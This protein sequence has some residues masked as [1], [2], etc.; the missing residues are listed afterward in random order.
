MDKRTGSS[1]WGGRFSYTWSLM[2]DNQWGQNTAFS[3]RVAAPQNF[4]DT[5]A[6]YAR[7]ILDS[8]H[9]IILA[10]IVRLPS[11]RT[12]RW[13]HALL[14]DWTASAIVELVSGAPATAYLS[15]GASESNLGLFG[16]RQRPNAIGLTVETVGSD[17]E[18]VASEGQA[19]ARWFDAAAFENPGAGRY[20]TL[21]RTDARGRYQFRKNIDAVLTKRISFGDR[22]DG[23]V[24]IE[25][26]NLTNTPKFGPA[27]VDVDRS[28]YGRIQTQR[29]F[30]RIWQLSVRV[31]Y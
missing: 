24:R 23:Q 13:L 7:S 15:A 9:R 29:G 26:I 11:P 8:P 16:G 28:S 30:S 20:G 6:E 17:T 4:Y 2:E 5:E 10:P 31:T 25:V 18:R 14:G 1:F 27:Q 22:V 21:S 3:G 19:G 12:G